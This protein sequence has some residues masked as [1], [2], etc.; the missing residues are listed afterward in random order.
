[1]MSMMIMKKKKYLRAHRYGATSSRDYDNDDLAENKRK[2]NN[3][4]KKW[5]QFL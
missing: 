5:V 2:N 1:M 4:V 3:N